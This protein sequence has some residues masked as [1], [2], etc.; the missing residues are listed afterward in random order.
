MRVNKKRGGSHPARSLKGRP[1]A[2]FPSGDILWHWSRLVKIK[3]EELAAGTGQVA[4]RLGIS[5]MI[6]VW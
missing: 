2:D 1:D 5:G 6:P 4:A 3:A